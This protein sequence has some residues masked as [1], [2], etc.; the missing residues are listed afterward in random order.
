MP[1]PALGLVDPEYEACSIWE[2][3]HCARNDT[4]GPVVT[5]DT[6]YLIG[7]VSKVF[8]AL[9][10]LKTGVDTQSR[11]TDFFP[12]PTMVQLSMNSTFFS[13]SM[14]VWAFLTSMHR[15][16]QTVV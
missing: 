2:Y 5:G 13:R 6:Q 16:I 10:L 3:H 14:R 11:V 7:S 12:E 4:Q 9:V 8:S 1:T 15:S